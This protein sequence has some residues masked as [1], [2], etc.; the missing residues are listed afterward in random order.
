MALPLLLAD[1]K[2]P[3]PWTVHTQFGNGG[4]GLSLPITNGVVVVVGDRGRFLFL[5]LHEAILLLSESSCFSLL[6]FVILTRSFAHYIVLFVTVV[7]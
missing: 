4:G 2:Q 5:L 7:H 3:I 1:E 6:L